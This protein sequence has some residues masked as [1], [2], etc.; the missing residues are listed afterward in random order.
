MKGKLILLTGIIAALINTGCCTEAGAQMRETDVEQEIMKE[1]EITD[2]LDRTVGIR[3][4]DPCA[5]MYAE[6]L[7]IELTSEQ[8][9]SFVELEESLVVSAGNIGSKWFYALEF[10]DEN[11]NLLQSWKID[12]QHRIAAGEGKIIKS[13]TA[14]KAWFEQM[15]EELSVE[16]DLL[17]RKPGEG[18]FY[19]ITDVDHGSLMEVTENNFQQGIEY[20]FGEEDIQYLKENWK[21]TVFQ[22]KKAEQ[23]EMKIQIWLYS[24]GGA[25]LYCFVSDEQGNLYTDTGYQVCG[26]GTSKWLEELKIKAGF[27]D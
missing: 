18:Y 26:E 13:D 5:D 27:S 10:Y 4:T 20:D 14:L 24:E 19:F 15:E 12:T 7:D 11:N 21:G 3:L 8:V 23:Q 22:E 6:A 16:F 17:E 25:D 9:A 2:V 1:M